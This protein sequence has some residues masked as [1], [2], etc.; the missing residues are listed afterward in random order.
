MGRARRVACIRERRPKGKI[1]FEVPVAGGK[2]IFKWVMK[3]YKEQ[4]RLD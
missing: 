1:S 3:K 2:I 4:H